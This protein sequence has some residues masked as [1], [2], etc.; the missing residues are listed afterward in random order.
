MRDPV[1]LLVLDIVKTGIYLGGM[2]LQ[3]HDWPG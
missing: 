2:V 1:S 3:E